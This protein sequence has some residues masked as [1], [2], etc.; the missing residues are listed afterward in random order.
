MQLVQYPNDILLQKAVAVDKV[1]PELQETARQMFNV[2]KANNGVGLAAP[3]V[4]LSI[5]L[6]VAEID[7]HAIYMFNPQIMQF[8]GTRETGIEG[9]LS[10]DQ[11]N[12]LK[13]IKRHPMIK[14]KY[15]DLNG[16][17][18]YQEFR[19]LAARIIQHEWD[20][21]EGILF[22]TKEEVNANL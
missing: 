3:Q 11:G 20:H 17:M 21:L 15:R 5:R 9:C 13:Q 16:K 4:G 8:M 2:M 10:F 1:T 6:I 19:G 18:Q 7:G 12:L 14:V 22:S